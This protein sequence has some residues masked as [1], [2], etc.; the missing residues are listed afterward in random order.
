MV[1]CKDQ[2]SARTQP[3]YFKMQGSEIERKCQK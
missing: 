2:D 1:H 3:P